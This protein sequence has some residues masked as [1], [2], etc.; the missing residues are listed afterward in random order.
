MIEKTTLAMIES[1]IGIIFFE[2]KVEPKKTRC[3]LSISNITIFKYMF[4]SEPLLGLIIS[5]M[6]MKQNE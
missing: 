5:Y 3:R 4:K 1:K 6:V 2:N